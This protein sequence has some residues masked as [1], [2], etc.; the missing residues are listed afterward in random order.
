MSCHVMSCQ[1]CN[2]CCKFIDDPQ[3]IEKKIVD[4]DS[5]RRSVTTL[6]VPKFFGDVGDGTKTDI[7]NELNTKKTKGHKNYTEGSSDSG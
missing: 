6:K 5:R 1:V 3:T 7:V 2:F 4:A